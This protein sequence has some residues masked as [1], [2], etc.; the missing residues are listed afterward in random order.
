M[1][2]KIMITLIGVPARGCQ[3]PVIPGSYVKLVKD[4]DNNTDDEAIAVYCNYEDGREI[5]KTSTTNLN[6]KYGYVANSVHTKAN[7]TYS[8]GRIYDKLK[9]ETIAVVKFVKPDCYIAE[10][11][12]D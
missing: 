7:G 8:A 4:S 3:L 5:V 6:K 1:K 9:E 11:E 2:Q 10:V 12:I